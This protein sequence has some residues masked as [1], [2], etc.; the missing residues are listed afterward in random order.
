LN[1]F[2]LQA[3]HLGKEPLCHHPTLNLSTPPANMLL[4][5]GIIAKATL[6]AAIADAMAAELEKERVASA[7]AEA[8]AI[9]ATKASLAACE[10][11]LDL[12]LDMRLSEQ[13]GETEY[14]SKKHDLVNRKAELR[15]K[16]ESFAENRRNRFEPAIRFVL[17]AKHGGKLLVEGNP[18]Q[19]RDFLKKIGSNLQVREKAL[20]VTFKSPWQFVADFN[21]ATAPVFADNESSLTGV[22]WRSVWFFST[23]PR[24]EICL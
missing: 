15:G 6:N 8:A 10:K 12:L 13:V 23:K 21:S 2:A 16:L 7:Q 22:N 1:L 17:E 14:V 4:K 19:K 20:G 3:F 24:G 5:L 9:E 11:R 18:E